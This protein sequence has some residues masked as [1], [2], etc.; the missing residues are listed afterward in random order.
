M[1]WPTD[2][3]TS[4]EEDQEQEEMDHE[5]PVTDAEPKQGGEDEEEIRP[6]D[7]E[8]EQEPDQ[9]QHLQ[10]WEAVMGKRRL[11]Y[12]DPRSDSEATADG[13][14]LRHSTPRE[15]G[16]PMEAA[17]EVHMRESEVEDL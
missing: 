14:S 5:L 12:D 8:D 9:R 1:S 11:V 17:V 2:S 3:S 7:Q 6:V 16:S 13:C 4:E 10:D 15:L